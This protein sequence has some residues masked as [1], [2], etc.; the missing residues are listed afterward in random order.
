[1]N[2]NEGGLTERILK[3]LALTEIKKA[4]LSSWA[5]FVK[6]QRAAEKIIRIAMVGKYFATGDYVLIDSYISVIEALKHAGAENNVNVEISWV[7]A[8]SVLQDSNV[9]GNHQGIIVPG[10]FGS[11]D[12]EGKIKAIEFARVN[13]VPYF[14]LCYGMQLACIEFSRNVLG[15]EDAHSTEI[16]PKTKN[17][18]IH[19]MPDQEKKMLN[20]DYG[21]TMRLGAWPCVL[22]KGSMVESC[23]GVEQISERHRHRYELNND[24]RDVLEQAGLKIVGTSP[25]GGLVE[26][27]EFPKHPFFV[28][29]QFHPELKSRPL[30]AH[31]LF[32]AF[33]EAAKNFSLSS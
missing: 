32:V 33:V 22:K 28:G 10:G 2:F 17:P 3:K 16:N 19:I 29:T 24:Y 26:I 12:I 8:G 30:A 1:M 14:G 6:R 5:D 21:G 18:V 15:L 25:D 4:D 31:P 20:L 13:G 11:R 27:V 23:Y 9:L 7:D